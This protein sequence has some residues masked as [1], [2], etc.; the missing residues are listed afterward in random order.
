MRDPHV[1]IPLARNRFGQRLLAAYAVLWLAAA[2]APVD[3][4]TWLLENLLVFAVLALLAAN[5]GRFVF[6]NLSYCLIFAFL[7][8]HSVGS[9]YTYSEVPAGFW[10]R[11][12]LGLERNHYDRFVHFAFG[13][14]LA[15]PLREM[16][17]RVVHAHRVWS[18]V[19]SRSAS[20]RRS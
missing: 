18:W 4:G 1:G 12:A 19:I 14:L 17:L 13:L 9:H 2:I 3:R 5:H 8:L 11:D 6:S 16:V 20:S 7:A 15:Y 10:L